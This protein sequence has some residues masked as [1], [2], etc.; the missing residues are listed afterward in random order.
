M[1]SVALNV[2]AATR[3]LVLCCALWDCVLYCTRT[4]RVLVDMDAVEYEITKVRTT[5]VIHVQSTRSSSVT[6]PRIKV[7]R[8]ESA[9]NSL[10]NAVPHAFKLISIENCRV[11]TM[12]SC[13]VLV[14]VSFLVFILYVMVGNEPLGESLLTFSC[15]YSPADAFC[16]LQANGFVR[17]FPVIKCFERIP[18]PSLFTISGC[19]ICCK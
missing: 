3:T 19:S 4:V 9:T 15:T 14:L 16:A 2:V 5:Q 6:N 12:T 11:L 17:R 7:L 18:N 8:N 10:S 13:N 1:M